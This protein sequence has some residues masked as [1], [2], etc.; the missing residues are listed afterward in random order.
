MSDKLSKN[1][2]A[3]LFSVVSSITFPEMTKLTALMNVLTSTPRPTNPNMT[4]FDQAVLRQKLHDREPEILIR[5]LEERWP[6]YFI[7][8]PVQ[9]GTVVTRA[10]KGSFISLF[11]TSF[12]H[13]GIPRYEKPNLRG[14]KK[15]GCDV[16][17]VI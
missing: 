8:L 1:Q 12:L 13:H 14:K 16:I 7:D 9:K 3:F 5:E 4:L 17:T 15:A 2:T 11:I 10:K 6:D